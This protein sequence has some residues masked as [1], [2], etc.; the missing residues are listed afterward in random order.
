MR[1][2][3]QLVV[4][5]LRRS[6]L[7]AKHAAEGAAAPE[8]GGP[9]ITISRELGSGGR[10]VAERLASIL[11]WSLWDKELVNAIARNASVQS[12][13]VESFDEKA[14]SEIEVMMRAIMGEHELGGFLYSRHLARAVISIAKRGN[15][16]ILGRGAN[17]L[18]KGALR[19][20]VHATNEVRVANLKRF[21]GWT[22]DQ[23]IEAIRKSDRER[24]VFVRRMFRRDVNDPEAYDL[25]ILSDHLNV[26]GT[27]GT[28]ITALRH[29]F[30]EVK[31]PPAA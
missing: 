26:E 20:R 1:Y 24:S 25:V 28:I 22:E 23:A 2:V 18:L 3:E 27:T 5:Q 17:F 16:I 14:I 13:V 9:V 21:E 8:T 30:P 15:A 19:V 12:K 6:E 4:E 10:V 11:N 7:A 29:R 31:L